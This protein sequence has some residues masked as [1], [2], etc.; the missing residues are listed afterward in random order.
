M[1]PQPTISVALPVYNGANFLREVVESVLAQDF[2]DFELVV[3]DNASTDDTPTILADYARRDGR[4]RVSRSDT[5]L[6]QADN[7]NRAVSL[8]DTEWVKLFCHDDL[9]A[10]NCLRVIAETLRE[11]LPD[12]LG[13]VGNG[14]QWLF[15]NGFIHPAQETFPNQFL[16]FS[17]RDLLLQVIRGTAPVPLPSLTTATVRKAAWEGS[18]KFDSRFVH[19]D[20]YLWARLLV[21]WDYRHIAQPLTINRIHGRQVAVAARTSLRT[22][23]N[24]RKFWREFIAE[25]GVDLELSIADRAALRMKSA[26]SAAT[27]VAVDLMKH[28]YRAALYKFVC[29]PVWYWPI[30]PALIARALLNESRR[31]SSIRSHVPVSLIYPN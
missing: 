21:G 2:G 7:V 30:A 20:V 4:V 19:F 12:H 18:G 26:S 8:C 3:S 5:L 16:A 22:V 28:S 17:G 29:T 10:P 14:E 9:M 25:F 23:S 27:A 1:P 15:A 31:I 24:Q 6:P 11:P 13:L